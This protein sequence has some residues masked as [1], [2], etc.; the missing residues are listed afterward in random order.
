MPSQAITYLT[1]EEYLA[2]ERKAEYK[3]EYIDGEMIAMT[4][5]TRIHN[6]ITANIIGELRQ[7]LKEAQCE[8]YSN[9]MRVRIPATGLYTYP[10]AIVVCGEPKLEDNFFDTLLNPTLI[11]EVLSSSTESHDRGQKF[12]DYRTVES[13]AEYLLVAQ[14][15]YRVEQYV[16]QADNRWLLTDIRSIEG[17]VELVSAP[18]ALAL[19]EIYHK[20]SLSSPR[21]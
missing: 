21:A 2:I 10:D 20:V 14:E 16:K 3:S 6:L 1:P 7:Q 18:C 17:T 12:S 9:D 19:N 15:E 8:V 11:V 4:G 13:L 5:A